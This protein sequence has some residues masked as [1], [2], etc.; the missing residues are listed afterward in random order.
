MWERRGGDSNPRH[1]FCQCN[2]LAGSP[3]RPLQHLSV[4]VWGH[5]PQPLYGNV[6]APEI[7]I[8]ASLAIRYDATMDVATLINIFLAFVF[9]N[10]AISAVLIFGAYIGFAKATEKLDEAVRRFEKGGE[11]REWL[12]SLQAASENAVRITEAAKQKMAENEP[13][14]EHMQARYEYNLARIDTKMQR[15]AVGLSENATKVRDSVAKPAE[16]FATMAAGIQNV[17]GWMAPPDGDEE[18][19]FSDL[20]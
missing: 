3:V 13:I 20:G 9:L 17:L 10:I 2:C 8:P 16:K 4:A 7:R 19:L 5:G 1:R 12:R 6:R 14:L 15:V 11:T 18:D